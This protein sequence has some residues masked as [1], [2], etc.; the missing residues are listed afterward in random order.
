MS[1]GLGSIYIDGMMSGIDTSSMLRQIAEVR[2]RPVQLLEMRNA[3]QADRLTAYQSLNAMLTGLSIQ[4][5]GLTN[6]GSFLSYRAMSSNSAAVAVTASAGASPGSYEVVVSSLATAQKVSSTAVADASAAMGYEG[7]IVVNGHVIGVD[8]GDSLSTLASRINTA[9]AG[10]WAT[11]V[12]YSG[13]DSRLVLTS[14][15]TGADGEMQL[16]D[17]NSDGLLQ[18]LGLLSAE[19][20]AKHAIADGVHSDG[21]ISP[22]GAVGVQMGLS[23]PPVGAVQINGQTVQIDLGEDSLQQIAARISEQVEGVTAS[24]KSEQSGGKTIYRLEIVGAEGAPELVDAGGVL[25]SLGILTRQPAN[26]LQAATNAQLTVDGI[27]VSRSS[28][29]I[30][31]LIPGV[32]LDLMKADP[33]TRITVTVGQDSAAVYDKVAQIVSTY[34]A[35]V[36]SMRQGLS[37]DTETNKGGSYFGDPAVRLLQDGLHGAV[38]NALTDAVGQT[39][40]P[41]QLG[42]S[43]DQNGR[44]LL[45]RKTF[46]AALDERPQAV[47]QMFGSSGQAT[48]AQIAFVSS[49]TAT[50]GSG[51]GGYAVH[52]TQA[53]ARATAASG[54]LSEGITVTERLTFNS[55]CT[56]E[57]V[58]GMSLQDAADTMIARFQLFD[59][60]MSAEVQGDT[61]VV[62]HTSYGSRY[63]FSVRSNLDAGQ[64]GLELGGAA[65]GQNAQYTGADVA[66]TINGE[67]A[68]GSGRYLTGNTGNATT[69]GLVLRVDVTEAG[70]YGQVTVSQG[71]AGRL[72]NYIVRTTHA[73]TGSMAIAANSIAD[74]IRYTDEQIE[75]LEA[76]VERYLEKFRADLLAMETALARSESLS[77]YISNQMKGLTTNYF[78]QQR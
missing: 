50:I 42:L 31:D 19:A 34:N 30:S 14:R 5:A 72:Q 10:V 48:D 44:L 33:N 68:S 25:C 29:S 39:V 60:D 18:S 73:T 40:L 63:G 6:T 65:A 67:Q 70:Q 28:N 8:S 59:L 69:E 52:I 26:Q 74:N 32:T 49:G 57:L 66:G 4:A 21:F 37:F 9:G 13:D 16:L 36:D 24:V 71:I 58:E 47:A 38:M 78:Q 27:A 55:V 43:T 56:V 2:R 11:V 54:S 61:L 7:D 35:V 46:M 23:R 22:A 53:A 41:S 15:Q 17:A 3:Q 20:S 62:S 1:F 45:D 51:P 12:T 75:R 64:G 76:G 77:Q